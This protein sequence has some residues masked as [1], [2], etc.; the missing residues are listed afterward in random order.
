M[1]A[2][3]LSHQLESDTLEMLFTHILYVY[4]Y[5]ETSRI[6]IDHPHF[7]VQKCTQMR[8]CVYGKI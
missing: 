4:M 3:A 6:G 7:W 5:K 2:K 1:S 8:F